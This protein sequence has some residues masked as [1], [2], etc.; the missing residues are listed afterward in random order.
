M[1][2]Y[3][4]AALQAEQAA[5]S[6]WPDEAT[7]RLTAIEIKVDHILEILVGALGDRTEA[8]LPDSNL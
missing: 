5:A 3:G 1:T 6:S 8:R 4:D 2:E 7:Q